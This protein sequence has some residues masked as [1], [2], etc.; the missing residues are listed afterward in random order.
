MKEV[1]C[2]CV[3]TQSCSSSLL[4]WSRNYLEAVTVNLTWFIKSHMQIAIEI[5]TTVLMFLSWKINVNL[6]FVST[7][8][9]SKCRRR[10]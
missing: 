6:E 10:V 2:A 7:K 3:C 8:A 4:C 9:K 1:L 5:D